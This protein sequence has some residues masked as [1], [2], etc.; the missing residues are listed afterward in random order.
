MVWLEDWTARKKSSTKRKGEELVKR[1]K[2]VSDTLQHLT[3]AMRERQIYVA[4]GKAAM[5]AAW[6]R[7]SGQ[8]SECLIGTGVGN[9]PVLR[10]GSGELGYV[11]TAQLQE[12]VGL[13]HPGRRLVGEANRFVAIVTETSVDGALGVQRPRTY[14]GFPLKKSEAERA[15]RQ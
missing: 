9:Q 3:A 14:L 11:G 4:L 8:G 12:L 5:F 2:L 7:K 1:P 13:V 6:A 10:I 15:P